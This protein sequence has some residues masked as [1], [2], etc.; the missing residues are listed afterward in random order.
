M[1]FNGT[2]TENMYEADLAYHSTEVQRIL[3]GVPLTT[4][5]FT[6]YE[7]ATCY[8]ER[9]PNLNDVFCDGNLTKCDF[10]AL[11]EHFDKAGQ[12][13]HLIFGCRHRQTTTPPMLQKPEVTQIQDVHLLIF[14]SDSESVVLPAKQAAQAG[15]S[16][17]VF[18]GGH[19]FKGF[20]TKWHILPDILVTMDPN[21]LVLVMDG[22]DVMLNIPQT[23]TETIIS[24]AQQLLDSTKK[25]Y[26]ALVMSK[27]NA[28]VMSAEG[29]CCV[30]ALTHASP[31]D[32]FDKGLNRM[33][34]A[35]S[36]GTDNC[37]WAGD[38]FR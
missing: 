38:I 24:M 35:C 30:A 23:D 12:D 17:T 8:A 9:Y 26:E 33:S 10:H 16:F 1:L 37:M 2:C 13:E 7:E 19:Q 3:D 34:R 18:G 28:V 36:S 5:A 20:G 15:L 6:L 31:G 29:S 22:R 4:N 27:P 14:E 32:F 11:A 25:T 21:A